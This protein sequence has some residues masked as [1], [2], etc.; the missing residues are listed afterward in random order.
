MRIRSKD[1]WEGGREGA[2]LKEF[3]GGGR[4]ENFRFYKVVFD[5]DGENQV[6]PPPG[7][8]RACT[9]AAGDVSGN[10]GA[11]VGQRLQVAAS[12]EVIWGAWMYGEE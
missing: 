5:D 4:G 6:S 12:S 7:C 1:R 10:S 11:H 3:S 9:C 2:I 8:H